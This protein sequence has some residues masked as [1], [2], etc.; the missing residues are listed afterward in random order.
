M[1][2]KAIL[3]DHKNHKSLK[4]LVGIAPTGAFT[5]VSK[6]WFGSTSYHK[7]VQESG[8][9]DLPKE[10]DHPIA[11]RFQFQETFRQED[12]GNLTFPHSKKVHWFEPYHG[13][14]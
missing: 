7:I 1:A 5:F 4:I 2:Q 3:N 9:I 13:K 8:P 12:G 11:C 14:I 6:L 10:V